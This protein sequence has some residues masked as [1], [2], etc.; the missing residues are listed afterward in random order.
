M[1]GNMKEVQYKCDIYM[2]KQQ[3]T[4]NLLCKENEVAMT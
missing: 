2:V 4:T 3:I 1:E